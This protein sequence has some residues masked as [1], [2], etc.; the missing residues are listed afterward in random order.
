LS[1]L[2][3]NEILLIGQTALE[4]LSTIMFMRMPRSSIIG[5]MLDLCIYSLILVCIMLGSYLFN[6]DLYILLYEGPAQLLR[7]FIY[8]IAFIRIIWFS[9]GDGGIRLIDWPPIG[10]ASFAARSSEGQSKP[11][12]DECI[13]IASA[14]IIALE[15]SAILLNFTP[16]W[17]NVIPAVIGLV[18]IICFAPSVRARLLKAIDQQA[19][20]AHT[21]EQY[22]AL[23]ER[24]AAEIVRLRAYQPPD[25]DNATDNTY[26][27]AAST[28][29][30]LTRVK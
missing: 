14:L 1:A 3:K 15:F 9:F 18:M 10:P 2:P 20:D 12:R 7:N 29:S 24:A 28:Q 11:T 8:I 23:I 19:D 13:W 26:P 30:H 6:R 25:D 17:S 27:A 4:I 22:E 5:N 16:V 21:I